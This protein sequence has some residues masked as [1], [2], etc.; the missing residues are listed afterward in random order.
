MIIKNDYDH[1]A[2]LFRIEWFR[3][4]CKNHAPEWYCDHLLTISQK[5]V[6]S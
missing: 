3:S 1:A 4:G 5:I 2:C 6:L